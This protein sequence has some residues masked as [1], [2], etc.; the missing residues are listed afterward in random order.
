M[1]SVRFANVQARPTEFLDF[2]S[3]TLEE[4]QALVPPLKPRSRRI[5]R[6][7]AS[8]GNPGPL[9]SLPSI[10]ACLQRSRSGCQTPHHQVNMALW[11]PASVVSGKA[12]QALL[13]SAAL[14]PAKGGA[15]RRSSAMAAPASLGGVAGVSPL[16]RP[17]GALSRPAP[18]TCRRPPHR[19]SPAAVPDRGNQR[20]P[21][22]FGSV[23]L[24]APCRRHQ[25]DE[26]PPADIDH[27]V[28]LAPTAALASVIASAPPWRRL[29]R[30]ALAT[31]GP[32]LTRSATG[33]APLPTPGGNIRS[34]P[35]ARR[36]GRPSAETGWGGGKAGG[37]MRHGSRPAGCRRW[38]GP[39]LAERAC[40]GNHRVEPR[41]GGAPR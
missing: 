17:P 28:A 18:P 19:P 7:G 3:L 31:L 12:S 37:R 10:S 27:D 30:L 34:Q 23:A 15:A 35:P 4:F 14:E 32:G 22:L 9:A 38:P 2:T 41:E 6:R 8:M 24:L 1:A 26:D 39:P 40:A 5:W 16:P 13:A 20:R 25:H 33:R 36:Q 29:H 11:P 21:D